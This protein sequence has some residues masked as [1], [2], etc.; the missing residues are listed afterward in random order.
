MKEWARERGKTDKPPWLLSPASS[1][2][3][4]WFDLLLYEAHEKHTETLLVLEL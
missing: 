3:V 4:F 2:I 1:S